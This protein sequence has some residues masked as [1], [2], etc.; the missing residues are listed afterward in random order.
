MNARKISMVVGSLLLLNAAAAFAEDKPAPAKAAPAKAEAAK[1]EAAKPDAG[2][3]MGPPPVPKE[4]DELKSFLGDWK[5]TGEATGPDGKTHK[6]TTENSIKADLGGYWQHVKHHELKSKENPVE[7]IAEG[8]WGYDATA[9]TFTG[10]FAGTYG[11]W[12][13]RT[14]KGWEGETLVWSGDLHGFMG[15]PK[16]PFKHSFTKKS[17]KEAGEKFEVQVAGKW[18]PL[19]DNVCKKK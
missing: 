9:K 4:M 16:T 14:S 11:A 13:T 8:W 18:V 15:I 1:L 10:L 17:D 5:C 7:F 2:K 6:V 12:E 3:P 19:Q